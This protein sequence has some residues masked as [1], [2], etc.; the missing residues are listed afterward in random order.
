MEDS[1][2]GDDIQRVESIH[3]ES[4][5]LQHREAS[6]AGGVVACTRSVRPFGAAASSQQ[7]AGG[8]R[9]GRLLS[10]LPRF[11]VDGTTGCRRGGRG[12]STRAFSP[13]VQN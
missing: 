7:G 4:S 9:S 13:C 12:V 2:R 8:T 6:V 10:L 1:E 5:E 11:S 3:R